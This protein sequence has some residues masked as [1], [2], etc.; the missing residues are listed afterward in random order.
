MTTAGT[1]VLLYCV[2][3]AVAI[4]VRRSRVPYTVALVVV[5]LAL[6]SMH[7]IAPPHLTRELLFTFFL[8]GLLFEAAFH[9]DLA[10]FRRVWKL[11]VGLAV[12]GVMMATVVMAGLIIVTGR[13]FGLATD[14][15]VKI[16]LVFA[17]LLAATDPVAVTALFHEVK[18]PPRLAALVEAESLFN[19]GTG[20]VLLSLMLAYATGAITS[21][22]AASVGFVVVA[23]GGVVIGGMVGWVISIVIRR[24]DEPMIE[25]GLTVIAAYG[26]FV[27]AER[28]GASGVL[29]TVVA[30]M[31]C[32]RHGRDLGMSSTSRLAVQTFWEYVAFALN[33]I[34]FL[35]IGF[36]FDSVRLGSVWVELLVAFVAMLAARTLI[37]FGGLALQ[38]RS[39]ERV[40]RR[41]GGIV[42]LGGLRGALSIVLALALPDELPQRE[43]IVSLTV[44]V[45]LLSIIVQGMSMPVLVRRADLT[46]PEANARSASFVVS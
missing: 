32:G 46:E 20:I 28:I 7:F 30:G 37:V 42:V 19:D 21:V 26:S 14:M 33:S 25:I 16:A 23:G 22:A 3:T 12:P 5:G 15:D 9:L 8:P 2:S 34:V 6:G 35:L 13:A 44:G 39:A 18:A 1:L 45:V 17:A 10:A 41:W 29:A 36:E 40:P 4:A 31:M 43:L 38:R 11:A 24:L 27:L